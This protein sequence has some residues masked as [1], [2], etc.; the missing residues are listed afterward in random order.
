MLVGP[1]QKVDKNV[2]SKSGQFSTGL[3]LDSGHKKTYVPSL[4]H[5]KRRGLVI[6][7]HT[8]TDRRI[9]RQLLLRIKEETS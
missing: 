9:L 3:Q 1:L 8:W 5:H 2:S 4:R 6:D 7:S